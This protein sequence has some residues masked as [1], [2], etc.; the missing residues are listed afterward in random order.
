MPVK[1]KHSLSEEI[2]M[3]LKENGKTC[4][5]IIIPLHHLSAGQTADKLHLEKAIKEVTDQLAENNTAENQEIINSLTRLK[6]EIS[7]N[8]NHLGLGLYVSADQAFYCTFPFLV[9][10]SS[11]V[12]TNFRVRELL[13]REQYSL[14]YHVLYV[15]EKEVRLYE[16]KLKELKEIRNGE[17][18]MIYD[19][20]YEYQSPSRSTSYAGEAHVKSFEKEKNEMIKKRHEEFLNQ[21]DDLLYKYL[22]N[23]EALLPCGNKRYTSAFLNRTVHA[24]KV[25]AVL[26]GNY[27]RFNEAEIADMVWPS[28]EAFI[29]EKMLDE[30]GELNEKTGEGLVEN[31]LLPVW[32]AVCNG[33][34][35]TLL[36][37][38]NFQVKA[39]LANH[40]SWQLHLQ[41]PQR[42]YT[43]LDDAVNNL[44]LI[45]LE[46]NGRVLFTDDG[47]L[48]RYHRVALITRYQ[49]F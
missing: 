5:S 36:V 21:A 33:R 23:S 29:H 4:I 13:M 34:G 12:D 19:E 15:D 9:A 37:E 28:I 3:L 45:A 46:K 40:N 32:E 31:G 20:S 16:G 7:F 43:V 25:I 35:E 38:K 18:P 44:V 10:E 6:E 47:M 11:T 17:F 14:A 8:R 2:K 39:Y 48:N 42:K 1:T 41:V 22:K 30:I 24:G 27:S 26:N 49:Y